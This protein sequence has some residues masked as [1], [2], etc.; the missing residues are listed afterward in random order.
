MKGVIELRL[1]KTEYEKILISVVLSDFM[2]HFN[3]QTRKSDA[4]LIKMLLLVAEDKKLTELVTRVEGEIVVTEKIITKMGK[5]LDNYNSDSF[6]KTMK[7][8]VDKEEKRS[9]KN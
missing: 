3:S 4:Q 1:T 9:S 8:A 5:I 6:E 7:K 2:Q